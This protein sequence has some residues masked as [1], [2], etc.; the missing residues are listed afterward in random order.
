MKK[1]KRLSSSKRQQ[2]QLLK[3]QTKEEKGWMGKIYLMLDYIETFF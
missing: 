1:N 2:R 3:K